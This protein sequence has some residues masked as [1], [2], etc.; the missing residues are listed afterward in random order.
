MAQREPRGTLVPLDPKEREEEPEKRDRREKLVVTEI[1][2][3]LCTP[4]S[5][6]SVLWFGMVSFQVR[7]VHQD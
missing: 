4:H 5:W 6:T 7:E 2:V 3:N 1:Q